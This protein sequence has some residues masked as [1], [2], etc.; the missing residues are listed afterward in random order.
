M[1]C[2]DDYMIDFMRLLRGS[3]MFENESTTD[4]EGSLEDS[5]SE[6]SVLLSE[7]DLEELSELIEAGKSLGDE[8]FSNILKKIESIISKNKGL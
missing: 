4:L 3:K 7:D 6:K 2:D 5:A 1:N 8:D